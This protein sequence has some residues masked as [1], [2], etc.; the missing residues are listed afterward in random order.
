VQKS[1]NKVLFAAIASLLAV[2]AL[3]Y[4]FPILLPFIIAFVLT[5]LMEPLIVFLQCRG[6]INRGLATMAAM[7]IV[8]GGAVLILSAFI[9]RLVSELIQLSVSLPSVARDLQA[10]YQ[11]FIEKMTAFY[12]GLPPGMIQ[13]LEQNVNILTANLQG[14]IGKSVNTLLS[15][16]SL[17]P[18]TVAVVIVSLLATYFL[19]RDRRLISE[20]I[21]RLLPS[22]WA[23]KTATV[24]QEVSVAFVGYLKAQIILVLITTV[25][26]VSGFYIIGTKYALT[27]GLLVG[28][29][30]LIPVLGPATIY[31]PWLAWLF[32]TGATGLGIKITILYA[33]VVFVRQL[34]ETK[35]VS[36]NLG[37]HPLATLLAMYGGLK[38]YGIIGLILG[39]IVLI[40][41]QAVIR[42]GKIIPKIKS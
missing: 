1:L 6:K 30:D 7:L 40:A 15:V 22:P 36:A 27:V 5:A 20:L 4:I 37:L 26:S 24:L 39:P 12:T 35:I 16:I 21:F 8:F 9:L 19:A 32:V 31:I 11:V 14:M 34:L 18:S 25:I 13:S 23:E 33:I 3:K 28:F 2:A 10:Y 41:L 29:F 38:I 17:V 42:A